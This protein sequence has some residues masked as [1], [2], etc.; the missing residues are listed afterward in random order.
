MH[1]ADEWCD[2]FRARIGGGDL[3]V[4]ER[5]VPRMCAYAE[6][7]MM[8]GRISFRA[9]FAHRRRKLVGHRVDALPADVVLSVFEDGKVDSREPLSDLPEA[10]VV[11]AV[12]A[13][14]ELLKSPVS[15]VISAT[16]VTLSFTARAPVITWVPSQSITEAK[17]VVITSSL[18]T[19]P[20]TVAT[21]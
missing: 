6:L 19:S 13:E 9:K 4:C 18:A 20:S 5:L 2:Q 1:C 12:A 17:M 3:L 8:P 16:T 7:A 11:S 10:F 21:S 15:I 14:I